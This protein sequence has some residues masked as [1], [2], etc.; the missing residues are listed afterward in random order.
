M[1]RQLSGVVKYCWPAS[2]WPASTSQSRNSALRPAVALPR[3]APGDERLRV[4]RAPIREVRYGID[5]RDLLDEGRGIDRSEQAAALQVGGNDLRHPARGVDIA[6]CTADE[7]GNR[8]RHRLEI[9]LVDIEADDRGGMA[10]PERHTPRRRCRARGNAGASPEA[11]GICRNVI[12][13]GFVWLAAKQSGGSNLISM[14]FH[15]S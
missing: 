12:M 5:A 15:W 8:D 2:C 11:L 13:F 10:R 7:I 1:R 14:S 4:D 9:A 6:S 3:D